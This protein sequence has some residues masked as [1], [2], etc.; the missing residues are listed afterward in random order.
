MCPAQGELEN[1]DAEAPVEFLCEV[2]SAFWVSDRFGTQMGWAGIANQVSYGSKL[3]IGARLLS[4]DRR[5]SRIYS[6]STQQP[7]AK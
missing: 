6:V 7:P 2:R 1:Q 4:K 5:R 3:D